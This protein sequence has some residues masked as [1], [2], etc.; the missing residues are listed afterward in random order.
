M[1]ALT[2]KKMYITIILMALNV[3]AFALVE[4]TGSSEDGRHMYECGAMLTSSVEEGE[5]W[6]IASA[7]FLHFGFLHLAN[8][9]L[10]LFAVGS[11]LEGGVGHLRTALIYII[12]G[13]GANAASYLWHH[14]R[15]EEVLSAGA[16][17]AVF[18][19]M[20]A[21]VFAGLFARDRLGPLSIRQIVLMLI[22]SLYH[23]AGGGVDDI[24]HIS[25]LFIGFLAA[26][27]LLK[28]PPQNKKEE[29]AL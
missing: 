21:M 22:L 11:F 17:G 2:P 20:G 9:L 7:M 19:L 12:S 10:V 23:G 14:I 6:R 3:L 5:I 18:G 4:I 13:L 24:A 28:L 26:F 29:P 1:T 8:N 16:S 15:G 25:G 27:I